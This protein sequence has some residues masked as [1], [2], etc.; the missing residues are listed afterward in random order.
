MKFSTFR[1]DIGLVAGGYEGVD[2]GSAICG[3]VIV[4][5][6]IVVQADLQWAYDLLDIVIVRPEAMRTIRPGPGRSTS[7]RVCRGSRRYRPCIRP[8]GPGPRIHRARHQGYT[9]KA[10]GRDSVRKG[11]SDRVMHLL[12]SVR[13]GSFSYQQCVF[14]INNVI[15]TQSCPFR[16]RSRNDTWLCPSRSACSQSWRIPYWPAPEGGCR[17]CPRTQMR[18]SAGSRQ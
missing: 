11:L 8:D 17:S 18:I 13:R 2:H 7:P 12:L 10:E 15:S 6:A 4:A 1:I 5:V 9:P 3:I 16:P 14:P